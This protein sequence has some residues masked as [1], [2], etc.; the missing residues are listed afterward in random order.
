ML[1]LSYLHE[2]KRFISITYKYRAKVNDSHFWGWLSWSETTYFPTYKNPSHNRCNAYPQCP[3]A[4][5]VELWHIPL[6]WVLNDLYDAIS[7]HHCVMY[8]ACAPSV[9]PFHPREIYR[10]ASL[11]LTHEDAITHHHGV[12]T[13]NNIKPF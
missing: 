12:T 10:I 8:H 6:W 2:K 13:L 1:F 7:L 3:G 5:F 9:P 4:S 11:P